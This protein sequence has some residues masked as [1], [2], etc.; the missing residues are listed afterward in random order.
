VSHDGLTSNAFRVTMKLHTFLFHTVVTSYISVQHLWK[1]G[2]AKSSDNL[3]ALCIN[4]NVM[5]I[6]LLDVYET[7]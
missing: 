2:F 4:A 5:L 7:Y 1:D 6:F 3:Y